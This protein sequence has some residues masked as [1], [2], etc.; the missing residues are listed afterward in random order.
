M[1]K[2]VNQLKTLQNQT[3]AVR[4]EQ[5]YNRFNKNESFKLNLETNF[6]KITSDP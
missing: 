3:G 2:C 4:S 5:N 1:K 6:R